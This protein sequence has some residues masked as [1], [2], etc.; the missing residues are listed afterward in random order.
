QVLADGVYFEQSTYYHVYALDFFLHAMLL[1]ERNQI[2][3]PEN[4][5][6]AVGKML[7]ALALLLE[8]GIAPRFGDDDGGRLFEPGRNR[9]EHLSDPLA[10]GAVLYRRGDF[11]AVVG[12]LCQETIWLLGLPG[13][14]QF[15]QLP[16][17]SRQPHSRE[18]GASGVY[19]MASSR[20]EPQQLFIDCGPQGA[21][22]AGHGHADALSIQF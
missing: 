20:P 11:K 3:V 2:P 22:T 14:R 13:V 8:A 1:A 4:L 10:T 17:I 15:D 12:Q 6:Q 19:V 9:V 16:A 7:E 21:H 5:R 18:L